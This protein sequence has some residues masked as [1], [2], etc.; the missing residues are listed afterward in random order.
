MH[1]RQGAAVPAQPKHTPPSPTPLMCN[2]EQLAALLRV[3][4]GSK[5][6]R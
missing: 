3:A 2:A 6:A 1:T 4:G 5:G